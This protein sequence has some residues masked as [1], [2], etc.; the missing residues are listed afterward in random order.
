MHIRPLGV[1]HIKI[2]RGFDS[3]DVLQF[4]TA[5][6]DRLF[7]SWKGTDGRRE[8]CSEENLRNSQRAPSTQADESEMLGVIGGP[9]RSSSSWYQLKVTEEAPRSAEVAPAI[10]SCWCRPGW[11][12]RRCCRVAHPG[13]MSEA[14]RKPCGIKKTM[15][16]SV[17]WCRAVSKKYTH[18]GLS[19]KRR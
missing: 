13:G 2:A 17:P 3:H 12:E 10:A 6:S 9:K 15:I 4:H 14:P 16:V 1:V 19:A 8:G 5:S 7:A 18:R 11:C